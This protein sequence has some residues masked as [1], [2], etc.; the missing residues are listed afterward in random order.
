MVTFDPV[1]RQSVHHGEES[2]VEQNC[3]CPGLMGTRGGAEAGPQCFLHILPQLLA[4]LL[5]FPP[6]PGS[7]GPA[8]TVALMPHYGAIW[9][10]AVY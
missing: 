5:K 1:R 4:H 7:I 6:P 8:L 3:C 10:L 2:M 9:E